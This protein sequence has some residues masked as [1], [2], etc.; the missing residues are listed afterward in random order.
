MTGF[1]ILCYQKP[2][3]N[4]FPPEFISKLER[5]LKSLSSASVEERE[6]AAVYMLQELSAQLRGNYP[7]PAA[8]IRHFLDKWGHQ[9]AYLGKVLNSR[10]RASEILNGKRPLSLSDLRTLRDNLG[11]PVDLLL[12]DPKAH[13]DIDFSRYPVG[14]MH[15]LGLIP[16]K[17]TKRSPKLKA[18]IEK[19]FQRAGLSPE[20]AKSACYR[21][22]LRKNEKSDFFALQVWLAAVHLQAQEKHLPFYSGIKEKDLTEIARFSTFADGPKRAI[23]FLEERGVSVVVMPHFRSTYVDGAIFLLNK[24]PVIGLSLRYDRVDNFWYTLGHELGH[25]VAEHVLEDPIFDDLEI[26]APDGIEYEADQIA[27]SM[28]IPQE[29]WE[30]FKKH[31]VSTMSVFALAARLSISPAIVAGRWRFETKN[32]KVFTSLIGHGEVRRLFPKQFCMEY[33][34]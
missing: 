19:F 29:D 25:L 24:K 8:A 23:A 22:S 15:R 6:A 7:T 33:D 4:V 32:Y 11:I 20:A 31:R 18:N 1:K 34:T 5:Q 13:G 26:H 14:E 2:M 12:D 17:L 9:E 16:E 27:Q 30:E 3:K 10:S 21:Q 28:F